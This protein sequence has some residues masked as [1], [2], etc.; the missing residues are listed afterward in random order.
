MGFCSTHLRPNA[1]G[2]WDVQYINSNLKNTLAK[3][4]PYNPGT[5]WYNDHDRF[6]Q[7]AVP[8]Q[9]SFSQCSSA[10]SLVW[11]ELREMK[12]ICSSNAWRY[13]RSRQTTTTPVCPWNCGWR[14]DKT[15]L[16][17]DTVHQTSRGESAAA[18]MTAAH[19]TTQFYF[20]SVISKIQKSFKFYPWFSRRLTCPTQD[21]EALLWQANDTKNFERQITG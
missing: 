7:K 3:L 13:L 1:Q 10:P 15:V 20:C 11:G 9:V 18:G 21:F 8:I 5:S 14:N 2:T 16:L 12:K 17:N 6:S 19:V 4:L